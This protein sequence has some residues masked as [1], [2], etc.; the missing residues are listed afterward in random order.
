MHRLTKIFLACLVCST[1][2][3]QAL[4][5]APAMAA[6]ATLYLSPGSASVANGSNLVVKVYEDSGSTQVNAVQA[7]LTY[8]TNLLS[9]VSYASSSAFGI[10]AE[11]PSGNSGS[12]RFA[13]GS[14]A[15][16]TGA[17]LVV[18]ITF[19]AVASSGTANVSFSSG[20]SVNSADGS[21]TN[22][23]SGTN[24]GKY[25]LTK[26]SST[27]S[28]SSGSS[29]SAAK[30]DKTPP[31]I[32]DIKASVV[33]D[34]SALITWKTSEPATSEVSYGEDTK[35]QISTT[36]TQ[37]VTDHQITIGFGVLA[38]GTTYYFK[39]KS[40]DAAGNKAMSKDLT[41]R[42]TGVSPQDDNAQPTASKKGL[43]LA[44]GAAALLAA[45]AGTALLIKRRRARAE[46]KKHFPDSDNNSNSTPPPPPSSGPT[47]IYPTNKT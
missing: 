46:L 31:K 47:I 34:A 2:A 35:H 33:T 8:P 18:T 13:R 11:N 44:A 40:S 43:Y 1:L 5:V 19:R 39:V 15:A 21:G 30:G 37:L 3:L 20:S 22:I 12:L 45:T 29:S 27:P 6:G 17:Q 25:T 38:A 9:Y 4:H 41:F 42:T 36:D 7:N 32:S 16:R 10:E 14:I 23:L 26:A 28:G 24:G